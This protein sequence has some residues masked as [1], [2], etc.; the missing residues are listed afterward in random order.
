MRG[1]IKREDG[2]ES[3]RGGKLLD[4]DADRDNRLINDDEDNENGDDDE[5]IG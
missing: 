3:K 1:S 5:A 2:M 4:V